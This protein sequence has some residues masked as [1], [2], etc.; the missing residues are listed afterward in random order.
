[1]ITVGKINGG[2]RNNII[3]EECIMDGTIRTLD[4]AMQKDVHER[5]KWTATKIAEASGATAEITIDT[6]TLGYL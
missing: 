3:P 6:K 2:V 1:M 5:I 4:N